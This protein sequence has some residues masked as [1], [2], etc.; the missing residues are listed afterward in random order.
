MLTSLNNGS[1]SLDMDSTNFSILSQKYLKF[2]MKL[3]EL[4][5]F[6]IKCAEIEEA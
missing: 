5:D 1:G 3:M 6:S 4:R 2:Y